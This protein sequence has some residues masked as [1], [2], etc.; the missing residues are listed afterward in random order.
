M[1]EKIFI[2]AVL[3]MAFSFVFGVFIGKM[4]KRGQERE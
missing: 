3:Y 2:I 4:I 1:T